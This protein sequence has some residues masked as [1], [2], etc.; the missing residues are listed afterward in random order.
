[1]I[2]NTAMGLRDRSILELLYSTALGLR[3]GEPLIVNPKAK[4]DRPVCLIASALEEG[5]MMTMLYSMPSFPGC[6]PLVHG[7]I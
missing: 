4:R 1:M 5:K 6:T 2:P 7:V 3:E